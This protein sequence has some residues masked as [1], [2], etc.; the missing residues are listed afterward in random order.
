MGRIA[1]A[2]APLLAGGPLEITE[3]GAVLA[4]SGVTRARDPI[5]AVRRALRDDPRFI[6]VAGGRVARLD[7]ALQ[8]V[9][10]TTRVADADAAAGV[11]HCDGDLAPLALL[12]LWRVPA[13]GLTGG[14]HVMVRVDDAAGAE[15]SVLPCPQPRAVIDDE[16]ALTR[17]VR[18]HVRRPWAAPAVPLSAPFASV[19]AGD[20]TAFRAPGRPLT[21]ALAAEWEVHL[22][23]VGARGTAW[24]E[25]TEEEVDAMEADVADLLTQ[26]RAADAALLQERLV[27]VLRGHLPDRVPAAR[28]RLARVLSRAGRPDEARMVLTRAFGF[29]DPEDRYEAALLAL[30]GGELQTARRLVEEGLARCGADTPPATLACLVDLAHDMDA[31]ATH[32]RGVTRVGA[33]EDPE[34]L[35]QALAHAL[36]APRRGYLVEA[37]VEEFLGGL[38]TDDA[39]RL[40]ERLAGVEECGTDAVL[41][42]A[43]VLDGPVAEHARALVGAAT[44]Q[45]PWVRGLMESRPV[46]AWITSLAQA[47]DQQELVLGI[48]REEGRMAPLVVLIDHAEMGGAVKEAFFLPDLAEP[49]VHRELLEPMREFGLPCRTMPVRAA[50]A[51]LAEALHRTDRLGWELPSQAHQQVRQRIRRW[52]LDRM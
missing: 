29:D 12:G 19:V 40:M 41:A 28:R 51:L 6:E 46:R 7:Q 35:P 16:M 52:V 11:L 4:R 44:P 3:L 14:Q 1:D 34:G 37:M 32:L 48:A 17:A 8:G 10:L 36:V 23:W 13:S 50:T 25:F 21:E 27:R 33:P 9:T 30:R 15:V 18:E 5:G 39:I 22:G 42:C 45:R 38:D 20:P 26:E 43:A 49:R 31:Q 2:A 24:R 47:P